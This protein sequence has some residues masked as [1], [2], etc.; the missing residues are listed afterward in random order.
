MKNNQKGF[1][2]IEMMI[3]LLII[4]VLLIITVPNI[5]THSSNINT[6]GCEGYM[7]MVEAQVQAYKMDKKTTP[8]FAELKS[9]G[10]LKSADA[11]CP[12]GTDIE[13]TSKGQVQP[14]ATVTP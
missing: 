2:L 12:D 3:V 1:T 10:Y 8:S 13:I 7:K 14:V 6:K 11:K 4:S 9:E 5:S